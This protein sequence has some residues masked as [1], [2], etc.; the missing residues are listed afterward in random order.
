[1]SL[2]EIAVHAG[3]EVL[4]EVDYNISLIVSNQ[5][6]I[7]DQQLKPHP[8]TLLRIIIWINDIK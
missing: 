2:E 4:M 5:W 8:I 3:H 7:L 6:G 1:M